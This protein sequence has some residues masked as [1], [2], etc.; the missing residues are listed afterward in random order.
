MVVLSSQRVMDTRHR[1]NT[2]KKDQNLLD[3]SFRVILNDSEHSQHVKLSLY[4]VMEPIAKSE[5]TYQQLSSDITVD[6]RALR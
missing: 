6:N 5:V 1:M 4:S 3:H 2:D